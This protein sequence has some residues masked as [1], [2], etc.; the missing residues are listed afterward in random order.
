MKTLTYD[1]LQKMK[2][3]KE[4]FLLINVLP[5]ETFKEDHIPDSINVPVNSPDFESQVEQAAGSKDKKVVT[6]CASFDC[7]ASRKAAEKLD[8]AG[9]KDVSAYEGGMKEWKEKSKQRAFA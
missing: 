4:D 7:S 5:A 3:N 9:F 2:K 1:Q 8:K 6:Y